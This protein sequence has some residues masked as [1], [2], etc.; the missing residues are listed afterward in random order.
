[1]A[2]EDGDTVR[3]DTLLLHQ[4]M[5]CSPDGVLFVSGILNFV[6]HGLR[7][8]GQFDRDKA[9]FWSDVQKQ[10]AAQRAKSFQIRQQPQ[11]KRRRRR[12]RRPKSS[13]SQ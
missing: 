12:R 1:M 3:K 11:G 10:S 8:V 5:E 9:T 7:A 2:P 4:F 6:D 13:S